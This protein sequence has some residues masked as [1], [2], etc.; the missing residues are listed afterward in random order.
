MRVW[1]VLLAMVFATTALATTGTA[2][3]GQNRS[4]DPPE[5]L[6]AELALKTV[7]ESDRLEATFVIVDTD[8]ITEVT[9]DGEVQPITPGDTV[10]VTRNFVFTQDVTRVKVT[11]TDE[12]GHT[13][14]V[15][16]TVFR[17]G[18]DPNTVADEPKEDKLRWFVNYSLA[19]ESDSN[20]SQD[21]SL[22]FGIDIADVPSLG[23][24]APSDSRTNLLLTGG[25]TKGRWSAFGGLW[26]IGYA[27]DTY[28]NTYN[29]T[30]YFAGGT[31]TFK[32]GGDYDFRM[33]Y[34]LMHL[35]IGGNKYSLQHTLSPGF[36]AKREDDGDTYR[37]VW[38]LDL[39][40]KQ[41]KDTVNQSDT[42]DLRFRY[43]VTRVRANKLDRR[44][45]V[46]A[47]GQSS[48]GI[49][50]TEYSYL[51]VDY[52]WRN[53]WESGLIWDIGWGIAYRNYP[54]DAPIFGST[55][56]DLPLRFSTGIGWRFRPE[57]TVLGSMSYLQ[58]ISSGAP[59]T[60]TVVGVG[61]NGTF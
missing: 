9:I 13:R 27:S 44:R 23:T 56:L 54:N 24:N 40:I 17:P 58:N 30:A 47:V 1:S 31:G 15:V 18:V 10:Q 37:T 55:R 35:E 4:D 25:V 26:N 16:Y 19:F 28:K 52:D 50:D 51:S 3:W 2:A 14:T 12:A 43:D 61:V 36:V 42:T 20:P 21:L 49:P 34:T 59:F 45:R 8:P 38:G 7:L 39:A 33:G 5:I 46:I 48:E 53:R 6:S 57:L 41:F 32:L 22:P 11:A 29:V 60:R